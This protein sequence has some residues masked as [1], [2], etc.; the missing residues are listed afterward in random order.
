MAAVYEKDHAY[1]QYQFLSALCFLWEIFKQVWLRFDYTATVIS[2]CLKACHPHRHRLCN[3]GVLFITCNFVCN[4]AASEQCSLEQF[5]PIT[6]MHYLHIH[7][8]HYLRWLPSWLKSKK[9]CMAH[10]NCRYEMNHCYA[11]CIHRQK[12][13]PSLCVSLC[14][15]LSTS[16]SQDVFLLLLLFTINKRTLQI[17]PKIFT[18]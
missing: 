4:Q 1:F 17:C 15:H 6:L 14:F 7:P 2:S 16:D 11:F 3:P 12:A 18:D 9:S 8:P 10:Y 5:Y 13:S